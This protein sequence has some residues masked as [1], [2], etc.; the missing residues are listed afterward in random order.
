MI[1][2]DRTKLNEL[3][4]GKAQQSKMRWCMRIRHKSEKLTR[5]DE[6]RRNDKKKNTE[7]KRTDEVKQEKWDKRYNT[8]AALLWLFVTTN[9]SRK[10]HYSIKYMLLLNKAFQFLTHSLPPTECSHCKPVCAFVLSS[11]LQWGILMQREA[12]MCILYSQYAIR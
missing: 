6:M 10:C 12:Q 7:N 3:R 11:C 1:H 9:D 4:Q 8:S 2:R 5:W